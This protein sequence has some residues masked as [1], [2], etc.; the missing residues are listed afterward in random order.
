MTVHERLL[1]GTVP[2]RLFPDGLEIIAT[3]P[4]NWYINRLYA[5]QYLLIHIRNGVRNVNKILN[6][7][8]LQELSCDQDACNRNEFPKRI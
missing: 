7:Y 6:Q 5:K 2:H 8:F 3:G 4:E 1:S